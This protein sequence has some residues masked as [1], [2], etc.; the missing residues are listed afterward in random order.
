MIAGIPGG[1]SIPAAT[2]PNHVLSSI[3]HHPLHPVSKISVQGAAVAAVP[4]A[5]RAVT[6]S[7][8]TTKFSPYPIPSETHEPHLRQQTN[9]VRHIIFQS[10]S[11]LDRS[12][13]TTTLVLTGQAA[14]LFQWGPSG[15]MTEGKST[16]TNNLQ[17]PN[18]KFQSVTAVPHPK[19][20]I[21]WFMFQ[22]LLH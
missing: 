10:D 1:S 22:V 5:K 16:C 11:D 6:V 20:P 2:R 17:S 9:S 21:G 4:G 19:I 14:K 15:G 7:P 3:V 18:L 12:A 8:P 13:L